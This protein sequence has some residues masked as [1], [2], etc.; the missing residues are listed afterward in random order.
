MVQ[1]SQLVLV[2]L[3]QYSNN[4][5]LIFSWHVPPKRHNLFRFQERLKESPCSFF[6]KDLQKHLTALLGYYGADV[7]FRR[8]KSEKHQMW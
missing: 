8:F 4:R 6:T 5:F 2:V 7:P 3:V 1:R